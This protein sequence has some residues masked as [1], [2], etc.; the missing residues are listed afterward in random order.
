MRSPGRRTLFQAAARLAL[1]CWLAVATGVLASQAHAGQAV[2]L[3]A[4]PALEARVL[5]IADELRC[6]VCQNENIAASQADLAVDLRR[7]IREQ[8]AEGR[9]QAQIIDFMVERYG[10]FI[11]YRPAFTPATALLWLGPFALLALGAAM[12]G[13]TL[14]RRR[15]EASANPLSEAQ[16]RRVR[17]LLDEGTGASP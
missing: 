16:A 9:S 13:A 2:P 4:D 7:Q 12:L 17:Q 10:E 8:L 11:R 6:L 14:R 5:R 1:A 15:R 3:A